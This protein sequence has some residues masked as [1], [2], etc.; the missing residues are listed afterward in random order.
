MLPV[1]ADYITTNTFVIDALNTVSIVITGNLNSNIDGNTGNLSSALSIN[2]NITTNSPLNN[3]GLRARVVDDS[4]AFHSGIY[5][6]S[7]GG[8]I[9]SDSMFLVLADYDNPPAASSINDCKQT[10]STFA[11]NQDVIAYPGNVSINN[12]GSF[13]YIDNSGE[14]YYTCQVQQDVTDLNMTLGIVPKAGTF[15]PVTALDRPDNYK[16][17]IYLDSL[18]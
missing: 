10:V 17:E 6:T 1:K 18:P 8:A 16:V 14:G 13:Q 7:G 2:F 4:S 9:S 3:I 5:S 15:D 12:G 11:N